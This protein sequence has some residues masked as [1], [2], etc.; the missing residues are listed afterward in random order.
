MCK[1]MVPIFNFLSFLY[2][3]FIQY[4][5]LD[6]QLRS[7]YHQCGR[8]PQSQDWSTFLSRQYTPFPTILRC[9][10]QEGVPMPSRW[11]PPG[12]TLSLHQS[13]VEIDPTD[14]FRTQIFKQMQNVLLWTV[15]PRLHNVKRHI[16]RTSTRSV[17]FLFIP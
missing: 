9:P 15:L 6:Y 7:R 11:L 17:P 10:C 8:Q 13:A 5:Q 3:P 12:R 14:L 16:H 4:Q 2:L 1:A